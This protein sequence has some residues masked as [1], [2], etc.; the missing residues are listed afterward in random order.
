M[1]GGAP[2]ARRP[3]GSLAH[4]EDLA[5]ARRSRKLRKKITKGMKFEN[6][7]RK[8]KI[9]RGCGPFLPEEGNL[10]ADDSLR[11]LVLGQTLSLP[12][13]PFAPLGRVTH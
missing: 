2:R 7:A 12:G 13:F 9:G 6:G 3:L 4:V 5:F 11:S 1:Q 10:R 8:K